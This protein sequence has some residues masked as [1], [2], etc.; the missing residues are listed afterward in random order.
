MTNLRIAVTSRRRPPSRARVRWYTSPPMNNKNNLLR[1]A[2]AIVLIWTALCA[3]GALGN[4]SDA[5]KRGEPMTYGWMLWLWVRSHLPMIV[6]TIACHEY[7]S[8]RPPLMAGL[9]RLVFGYIAV[10]ALF[11]PLQMLYLAL[12]NSEPM[13]AASGFDWFLEYAWTTFTFVAVVGACNMGESRKREHAW[14][15]AQ[16]ENLNL[17]LELEQQRLLALRGQLNPHFL[18]NA[19]NA[20]SALV[21]SSDGRLA[22]TGIGHLSDL[23]RYALQASERDHVRLADER[24]FVDDYLALQTLRYGPRLQVG[25]DD[26]A[27]LDADVPPLLLQPLIENALR[28]D[29]DCH[30]RSSDI[31]LVFG[32]DAERL[33]IEVS[34]PSIDER[35]ANPGLGLGLRH[36]RSRLQLAYGEAATLQSGVED[37]RFVVSIDMPR[38]AKAA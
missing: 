29:L 8:R 15:R 21:R 19:L 6:L 25:I 36:S 27:G 22:L 1:S 31:R 35:A 28:H 32:G 3:I 5:V 30:D 33:R 14:Q 17:R 26:H 38:Y 11:L 12:L 24:R 23:L 2:L 18:F 9:R 7:Y 37:G 34:N 10:V 4:Y 16:S 20:I 13:A